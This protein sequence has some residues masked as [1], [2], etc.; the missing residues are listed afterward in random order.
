M[1]PKTKKIIFY[2]VAVVVSP[3][4]S[5]YAF[6]SAIFYSWMNANGSWSAEKAAPWAYG[7]LALSGFFFI[8]CIYFIVKI[9]KFRKANNAT[10][11][12]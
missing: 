11:S 3:I 2:F 1:N 9:V 4:L 10:E 5:F 12:H 7:S 8:L 6:W